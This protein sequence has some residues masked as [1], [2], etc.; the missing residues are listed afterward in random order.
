MMEVICGGV[1]SSWQYGEDK[2][3]LGWAGKEV[4]VKRT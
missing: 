2:E 4:R 3:G 1:G